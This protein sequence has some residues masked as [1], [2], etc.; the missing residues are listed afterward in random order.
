MVLLSLASKYIKPKLTKVSIVLI[1][2]RLAMHL[3]NEND[4]LEVELDNKFRV[5]CRIMMT[6]ILTVMIYVGS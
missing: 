6:I 2:I 4:I 1:Q 3:F 5:Q